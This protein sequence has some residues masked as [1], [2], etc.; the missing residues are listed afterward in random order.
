MHDRGKSTGSMAS[1]TFDGTAGP[2]SLADSTQRV[3][4]VRHVR[5]ATWVMALALL[6]AP[7]AATA[8]PAGT[9]YRIGY[10]SP[11]LGIESPEEAFLQGSR[12]LG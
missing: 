2:R 11:R 6:A 1:S 4:R 12:E 7:L 10:L 8:Q 5:R 9:V 3:E